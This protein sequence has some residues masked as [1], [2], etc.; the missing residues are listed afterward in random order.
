MAKKIDLVRKLPAVFQTIT[1]E[2][3]FNATIDQVFSKKNSE[4]LSGFIGRR[5]SGFYDPFND[6][7][8]PEINKS[9]THY[10]LE[11]IAVSKNP[12]TLEKTN[13]F[14]YQDMVDRIRSLG[15]DVGNHDRI[16]ESDIYSFAPPINMDK[17]LN[18]LSYVW[19]PSRIPEISISGLGVF[20]ITIVGGGTVGSAIATLLDKTLTVIIEDGVTTEDTIAAAING[21]PLITSAITSGTDIWVL[22]IG[23]DGGTIG[24]NSINIDD[25]IL[26][27]PND[28]SIIESDIIGQ[29]TYIAAEDTL[30]AGSPELPLSNDMRVHF[31][32]SV[33]YNSDMVPGGVAFTV[34]GVGDAV[35]G[36]Q[37]VPDSFDEMVIQEFISYPWDTD[38]EVNN[39]SNKFWDVSP[40]DANERI[41]F[42]DYIT[43]AAGAIDRNAWSRTNKW[44]HIDTITAVIRLY[45][46]PFPTN[47]LR[48]TRP[49]IEFIRDI[50][51]YKSGIKF[52]NEASYIVKTSDIN[53]VNG[54]YNMPIANFDDI[55]GVLLDTVRLIEGL[56][57]LNIK[58]TIAFRDH[59]QAIREQV[60]TVQGSMPVVLVANPVAAID[61]DIII[62][63]GGNLPALGGNRAETYFYEE[64]EWKATFNL[65]TQA[66]QPPVFELYDL[67]VNALHNDFVYPNNNFR[68]SKVFSYE[69]NTD[70]NAIAD[71]AIGFPITYRNSVQISDIIFENNLLSEHF[72][73]I[74][75]KDILNIGGYSY[76]RIVKSGDDEADNSDW[77][78][79]GA[80]K[81][82]A[83]K[84]KQRVIDEHVVSAEDQTQFLTSVVPYDTPSIVDN[85]TVIINGRETNEFIYDDTSLP[86]P[87]IEITGSSAARLAFNDS[88]KII[89]FTH[90]KLLDSDIGY[91]EI[92]SQLEVNPS[93][94]EIT[95]FTFG[96]ITSHFS[97]IMT[98]QTGFVGDPLGGDNNF[99]DT[100]QD[101]S[102]GTFIV[103]NEAS[104]LKSMLVS[105]TDDIDI[106]PAIRFAKNEYTIFRGNLQ[107]TVKQLMDREFVPSTAL[108][109]LNIDVW[110]EEV[111]NVLAKSKIFSK[112]FA[113]SYMV[114][115]GPSFLSETF[116]SN[117]SAQILTNYADIT[118]VR[119]ELYLYK[120]EN[121]IETLLLLDIDYEISDFSNII[122]ITYPAD[123]QAIVGDTII[124]KIYENSIPAYIPSTPAKL[125][126]AL[127]HQPKL[128]EDSTYSES[129]V[130][131]ILG[132]DGS[133]TPALG[134]YQTL[135]GGEIETIVQDHRDDVLLEIE[136][137]IYNGISEKFRKDYDLL[138]RVEA[139]RPGK[140]RA[141]E[142][143]RYS[144][145][146][147]FE[148][149]TESYFS[150]WTAEY[151][152]DFR[153]NDFYDGSNYKT[154]NYS[155]QVDQ[156][157]GTLPGNWRGIFDYYYDTQTPAETP[158]RMIGF[159]VEPEWWESTADTGDGW[160]GYGAGPW[161]NAHQLWADIEAGLVRRGNREG[162]APLFARTGLAANTWT[163]VDAVGDVRTIAD[164]FGLGISWVGID[165]PWVYGDGAPVEYAWASSP[166][167]YFSEIEFFYLMKTS[168]FGEKFWDPAILEVRNN[169]LLSIATSS[170]L[171]N[172]DLTVHGEIINEEV[173]VNSG[174]QVYISDRLAFLNKNI[175]KLFGDKLRALTVNLAHKMAGFS[176]KD[177]IKLFL[178]SITDTSASGSLLIP[179]PNYQLLAHTSPSVKEYVYSGVIVRVLD[180]G[181]FSVHGYDLL[182]LD[183]KVLSKSP[184]SRAIEVREGGTSANFTVFTFGITYE[185]GDIVK[186]NA[187]FF[188]AIVT[189]VATTFISSNWTKINQ[190]PDVGGLA[191]TYF[192]DRLNIFER[193]QYGTVFN[194][195]QDVFDFLIGYG[196]YLEASGWDFST[197][198]QYNQIENWLTYGKKFL[199]WASSG[200]EENNVLFL[201]PN[202]EQ[203]TLNVDMGYPASV[204]QTTNGVYSILNKFGV[205]VNPA[206]TIINRNDR[207]IQV[208]PIDVED[209][210][211]YL[212]VESKETE[213]VLL[214]DNRTEFDDLVYDPLFRAR[215]PR[216]KF[217]GTKTRDW[218]GK[219]EAGGYLIQGDK[220]IPNFE[221]IV[222]GMRDF[223]NTETFHDNAAIEEAARHL[224]GHE[225]RDYL[226][227]L[228]VSDDVQ[229]SFYQGFIRQKGTPNVINKLLRSNNITDKED[230]TLG[231]E[232]AIKQD[233]F[234]GL[235]DNVT[236]EVVID[237]TKLRSDPQVLR[238]SHIVSEEKILVDIVLFNREEL[239]EFQPE[240]IISPPLS[241]AT[242]NIRATAVAILGA[243]QKI[244][245][246]EIT[247][248]GRGYTT[249]PNI[250][251]SRSAISGTP[252]FASLERNDSVLINQ[253]RAYGVIRAF[254]P[255]DSRTDNIIDINIADHDSWILKPK[256]QDLPFIMPT[257]DKIDF[258]IP[259][260]GYANLNDVTYTA[261]GPTSLFALW[262]TSPM[263]LGDTCWVAKNLLETWNV[264]KLCRQVEHENFQ[265][266]EDDSDDQGFAKLSIPF[267]DA[268]PNDPRHNLLTAYRLDASGNLT[269]E[270]GLINLTGNAINEIY[271]YVR[272]VAP[273]ATN[274]EITLGDGEAE[275]AIEYILY[276]T[277]NVRVKFGDIDGQISFVNVFKGMRFAQETDKGEWVKS[278]DT[279]WI[280]DSNGL[281]SVFR[282]GT[283]GWYRQQE[284]LLNSKLYENI[285]VRDREK[286]DTLALLTVLDPFKGLIPGVAEQNIDFKAS[287]DPARYNV[288][289][290]ERLFDPSNIFDYKHI[291]KTWWDFTN[292][293]VLYYEQ[294]TINTTGMSGELIEAEERTALTYVQ[295]H[296]GKFFPGSTIDIYEWVESLA[297]P[298]EYAGSGSPRSTTDYVQ[299]RRYN[300]A[301]D[302][303][304]FFYYFWVKDLSEVPTRKNRTMS[305]IEVSRILANPRSFA[306]RWFA[307]VRTTG[308]SGSFLLANTNDIL[309]AEPSVVQIN[310]RTLENAYPEHTEW[311]LIRENDIF[312]HITD[313]MWNKLVDSLVG[314]TDFLPA[315]KYTKGIPSG[316]FVHATI[317]LTGTGDGL[318]TAILVIEDGI[319]ISAEVITQG[320]GYIVSQGIPVT[321]PNGTGA[322]LEAGNPVGLNGELLT[323]D[324]I[325]GGIGYGPNSTVVLPVPDH[326]LAPPER[327][328]IKIR[329]QQSM[330]GDILGARKAIIHT[331]NELLSEIKIWAVNSNW[332]KTIAT[333]EYWEE[334]DWFEEGFN[335]L[336]AAASRR[337]EV[338][339]DL[340][341]LVPELVNDELVQVFPTDPIL[342]SRYEVY[343]FTKNI[344]EQPVA[345]AN[346]ISGAVNS[347]TVTVAGIGYTI[348][349]TVSF[350]GDGTGATG[351]AVLN[352]TGGI[353]RIVVNTGGSGYT[354]VTV[355]IA[356]PKLSTAFSLIRRERGTVKLKDTLYNGDI[357]IV[358]RD[359]F[360][361]ILTALRDT[362][363]LNARS[364]NI[365]KI[366]ISALNY[367]LSE[368]KDTDWVF[369]T[370]Y[371][372]LL[373]EGKVLRQDQTFKAELQNEFIAYIN[374]AK[375]Y[376]TKL[377]EVITTVKTEVDVADGNIE[378]PHLFDIGMFFQRISCDVDPNCAPMTT[379]DSL[380]FKL[381]WESGTFD[382]GS[383]LLGIDEN[384]GEETEIT[385]N[386]RLGWDSL[387]LKS[388]LGDD[389][390]YQPEVNLLNLGDGK[391]TAWIKTASGIITE[392]IVD[393]AGTGYVASSAVPV[394]H[395]LGTGVDIEI[396]SVGGGG[397]ILT[398][399]VNAGGS[400]YTTKSFD[401][402]PTVHIDG[403]TYIYPSQVPEEM[404]PV[405]SADN[406]VITV[407][408]E[409]VD[410]SNI[411]RDGENV[412]ITTPISYTMNVMTTGE[413]KY[414]RNSDAAATTLA[415]DI[416][417]NST[418]IH[419]A[420][421]SVI[422]SVSGLTPKAIW[423]GAER[424]EY[425]GRIGNILT[426][427]RRR[428]Q[429]TTKM[430]HSVGDKVFAESGNAFPP[431][432]HDNP[433]FA[434]NDYVVDTDVLNIE[435]EYLDS[436]DMVG[437]FLTNS[438]GSAFS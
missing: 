269:L 236:V 143:N 73:Y 212:R 247:N 62:L 257:I 172:A 397:E 54:Q 218:F 296:W 2:K 71:P 30:F 165:S 277:E 53:V 420:D 388:A 205:L 422:P 423:V 379:I 174:Y 132:H 396:S 207:R 14:F 337:V 13:L 405:Q 230:I 34:I 50:Q 4:K 182:S 44:Y 91:F 282:Q 135:I 280:D 202:S 274:T 292:A 24:T 139:I 353:D 106:I 235:V 355:D 272:V 345:I 303:I 141:V 297:P 352:A 250:I 338:T 18:Y 370:T 354:A 312:T 49:I 95:E 17:Y 133:K 103:Q 424:I 148:R 330:F 181:K 67:D 105:S 26:V 374:E 97:S 314:Y 344:A 324:V 203:I 82:S 163:P 245:R 293:R 173:I 188:Q 362:L 267:D 211:F 187:D 419:I 128:I 175:T 120:V 6:F 150:K 231:E 98:N 131:M 380:T 241:G 194:N 313:T 27:L 323:I 185:A 276:D 367:V 401:D 259:N 363:F 383:V 403:Q 372:T 7:Y 376:H 40:W 398:F 262:S 178:E 366:Y 149:I 130:Y 85:I 284:P 305:I 93:N 217:N 275:P 394:V 192:P 368:Q 55:D 60:W 15:G 176:N 36:I 365:N 225:T 400:G 16:F 33:S 350:S 66:N 404:V 63:T 238:L 29:T 190:L 302:K 81:K 198:N 300:P 341:A 9:R 215:Q 351:A 391:A 311:K 111:F 116:I 331:I 252:A 336:N 326:S 51:L 294:P 411:Q 244:A 137:R 147:Y 155:S 19:L 25:R 406:L 392:V 59:D 289:A 46:F 118:D 308:V 88:I 154:W 333:S 286:N 87:F 96:D 48:A 180:N 260:A 349:P 430:N 265:I 377:R 295:R 248:P 322:I 418:V 41:S 200:W 104:L 64:S 327:L 5:E 309:A 10:Q 123:S 270:I 101:N 256:D 319:I 415:M 68:G 278:G 216:L 89:T 239:Y 61:Q 77:T 32:A 121:K 31:P 164:I 290:D 421:G 386:F 75:G 335:S 229:F 316:I 240:I 384:T 92:P 399:T 315:E 22:G 307:P 389:E 371:V 413:V 263:Q 52:F 177:T 433:W 119:N 160:T 224:I 342:T 12:E 208:I 395:P 38:D 168:E 255:E 206:N 43:I 3:F 318:A 409:A 102:L 112:A 169:Q 70:R 209:A 84:S 301:K 213:H 429:D 381:N 359:E 179:E 416:E 99:R 249:V 157:G 431:G 156:L 201:S 76:Y 170:R 109:E 385:G 8:L 79:F 142:Q 115:R 35:N 436:E 417:E 56:E 220:I 74:I 204:E 90:D 228:E 347:V 402:N 127:V 373:Q 390:V 369:K 193:V 348:A 72:A 410:G 434:E 321:H 58:D 65:K 159:S 124:A 387:E 339:N 184:S 317:D 232:W 382:T 287:R 375:P 146:E 328:G 356:S 94:E 329:P 20:T 360:R 412:I 140:F 214:I 288:S 254:A 408:T 153:L 357:L 343:Q 222:T 78:L 197:V 47:G 271:Q 189:H 151:N 110:V 45:N 253:D 432:S 283:P 186:N 39:L 134:Q 427:I 227:G 122:T 125:G 407:D 107:K 69:E 223:Y 144:R 126:C 195:H 285:F 251:I 166:E 334:I 234:G 37:L 320:T 210:V 438:P 136:R 242:T 145:K 437:V 346:L 152:L 325:D 233:E 243:D 83:E 268:L 246:I 226:D 273:P 171:K 138:L 167:Y 219:A 428:T 191:V 196:A 23:S 129:G 162:I 21:S 183:F 11:P 264:Y 221:N 42:Q 108:G 393:N 361:Q 1:E 28:D 113:Y 299:L 100:Q 57:E 426:N 86:D 414:V 291:G 237:P 332:H 117:G 161:G 340:P 306:Y 310:Y 258:Q 298:A 281:W 304:Q 199:F 266:I 425:I 279:Y 358:L 364:V 114:A 261:F 378:D 158:W 80:W 435:A